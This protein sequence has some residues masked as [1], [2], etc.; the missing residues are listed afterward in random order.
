VPS[1]FPLAPL[2]QRGSITTYQHDATPLRGNPWADPHLRDVHVYTPA[3]W[4]RSTDLPAIL[5][6]AGF[7]GT[8]EG[9]LARGLTDVSIATRIDHLI[10]GGCPPFVAVMPDCMTHLGGS[11]FIDSAGIGDYGTWLSSALP[12]FIH[13]QL[14]VRPRWGVAGRSSGGYGALQLTFQAP[15]RFAAVA[16]HA[17]DMGFDL[18]YLGDLGR[19]IRG[20]RA[21]GGLA[22]FHEIFWASARPTSDMF[23]AFNILAMSAA[24]SP[25]PTGDGFPAKL[26]FD[27][28]TGEVFFEVLES[29]R[30]FDPLVQVTQPANAD[31]L[32]QLNLLFLDAGRHDEYHLQLG[33]RRFTALLDQRDIAYEYEEFDGGH[34][35]TAFRYDASL[36]KL[37]RALGVSP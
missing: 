1:P 29:W 8:G 36:P 7:A 6:L 15:H 19:A 33:A 20:I 9:L 17:G 32:A 16:C 34:R 10:A 28:H 37:A 12:R 13:S 26:P 11:Q 14:P 4:D 21:A 18:C 35:G 30:A 31:A 24:Y 22:K 23:A 3:G 2:A 27:P 25:D 5:I